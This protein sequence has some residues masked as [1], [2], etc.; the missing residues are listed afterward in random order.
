MGIFCPGCC[1]HCLTPGLILHSSPEP[2]VG[3][4]PHIWS[5]AHRGEGHL[6]CL[7]RACLPGTTA[8]PL[9]ITGCWA[10]ALT[11]DTLKD[12]SWAVGHHQRLGITSVAQSCPTLCNP[13]DSRPPGSPVH[14]ILQARPGSP[15]ESGLVSRE[16]QG[17][18]SPL[19]SRRGSLG[20][21]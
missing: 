2:Y 7:S 10:H 18:R 19:E 15:G 3:E 12:H 9:G 13:M 21:P 17:L 11:L 20:A 8:L 14:R 6:P 5:G 1:D 16:S 4:G